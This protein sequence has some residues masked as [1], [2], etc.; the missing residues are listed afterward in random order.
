MPRQ[1][2]IGSIITKDQES[3]NLVAICPTG[4]RWEVPRGRSTYTKQ[5][6]STHTH[7]FSL[8]IPPHSNIP[9]H[10]QAQFDGIHRLPEG[11]CKLMFPQSLHHHL[12]Q[13]LQLVG[14]P[15]WLFGIGHLRG[16]W[17]GR[18]QL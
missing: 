4:E 3:R 6:T 1:Q 14:N 2:A 17:V 5:P 9:T 8:P 7:S 12:V 16:W 15:S 11:P 18:G 13:V 10:R